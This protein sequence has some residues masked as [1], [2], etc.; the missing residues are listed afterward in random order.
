MNRDFIELLSSFVNETK[1]NISSSPDWQGILHLGKI[2][3]VYGILYFAASRLDESSKPDR[4]S[5]NRLFNA[6]YK[7]VMEMAEK[8]RISDCVLNE[9]NKY[10]IDAVVF[11]GA[12]IRECYPVPELRTMGD[13]DIL[14]RPSDRSLSDKM[15]SD[16]K[17]AVINNNEPIKC[18]KCGKMKFEVHT[19]FSDY[20]KEKPALRTYFDGMWEHSVPV[21]EHVRKP[22]VNYHFLI[23]LFH[24]YKHFI[25]SGCGIRHFMDIALYLKKHESEMDFEYIKQ[26]LLYLKLYKFAQLALFLCSR[27]FG[28]PNVF[29]REYD[30]EMYELATDYV[31]KCGV[32]GLDYANSGQKI[33]EKKTVNKKGLKK[34]LGKIQFFLKKVFP[35]F[36]YMKNRYPYLKKIPVLLP[37]A[38]IVFLSQQL[39]YRRKHVVDY[40]KNIFFGKE[41]ISVLT[42]LFSKLDI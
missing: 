19:S 11:K 20:S 37:W 34:T 4:D 38:W 13:A 30:G 24:T 18:Y 28:T 33:A 21:S 9:F 39:R 22:D 15:F 26:E 3:A 1:P 36:S 2:H 5:Q 23:I 6:Y 16:L 17:A 25:Y 42:K 12:V 40:T 7:T 32:F 29:G 8:N 10:G 35:P 27:W 14:I 31:L 41:D